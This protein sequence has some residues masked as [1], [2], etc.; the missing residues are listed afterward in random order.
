M[1]RIA[2]MKLL[3]LSNLLPAALLPAALIAG[4]GQRGST[5]GA[6]MAG[7]AAAVSAVAEP[8][9]SAADRIDAAAIAPAE[10]ATESPLSERLPW[11][12]HG[13]KGAL[14]ATPHYRIYTTSARSWIEEDASAFV[15]EALRHYRTAIT[16]LPAPSRP[17][18]VYI[19]DTREQ[20]QEQ[21]RQI[22]KEQAS[23]Y[24]NL[25]R[26]GYA[27][28]GTAVLYDIGFSDTFSILS[29]EGWH[30]Y[31][32]TVFKHPLPTWLEEGLATFMEGRL[33][34]PGGAA[35][36]DPWSNAQ[37]R[38]ALDRAARISRRT[39]QDRLIPLVELL[40]KSPQD[41]LEGD[42][43]DLLTYYAQV[44]ALAQFLVYGEEGRYREGLGRVLDD[45]A[46]GR[47]VSGIMNA[48]IHSTF[49]ERRR[50]ALSSRGPG[51][52]LAYFNSDLSA[53]AEEY[54]AFVRDIISGEIPVRPDD[55]ADEL[56]PA[57]AE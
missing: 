29:H 43:G 6:A 2:F 54:E 34:A 10:E 55:D 51:V 22:M 52:V 15:E 27:T 48:P 26:G 40:D 50:W 35:Q 25:G 1:P 56:E 21:T 46:E 32:Q 42:A 28:R 37:R 17:L 13:A 3:R 12:F 5:A 49:A 33:H 8:N 4:C 30:Q 23:L 36:F 9:T 20:W 41:F 11:S 16:P 7:D 45:A 24:L 47:L 18:E 44:W 39:K 31:T 57:A 19:F 53:F 38:A 14:M